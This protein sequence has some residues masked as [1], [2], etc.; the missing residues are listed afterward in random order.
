MAGNKIGGAK[1]VAK[2][3]AM[4]PLHY[5]KIG[6]KGGRNGIGHKFGHGKVDPSTAGRKGGLISRRR[7]KNANQT[8]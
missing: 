2:N 3:L 1:A 5:V 6:S 8:N 4:D 7:P